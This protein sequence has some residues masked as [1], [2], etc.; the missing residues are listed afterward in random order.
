MYWV[1]I[2]CLFNLILIHP[3]A[4]LTR[5]ITLRCLG[6][7]LLELFAIHRNWKKLMAPSAD[8]PEPRLKNLTGI[9]GVKY[10]STCYIP[11][12]FYNMYF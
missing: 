8:G 2:R 12:V 3:S 6:I 7:R 1:S 4:T 9:A 5:S 11:I 10:V